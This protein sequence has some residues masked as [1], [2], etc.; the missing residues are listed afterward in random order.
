M[1]LL[2]DF[3]SCD[4]G[5]TAPQIDLSYNALDAVQLNA[6]FTLLAESGKFNGKTIKITGAIGAASCDKSIITKI[7]G[8]VIQ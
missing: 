2:F 1:P 8:N 5:S 7:G 6:L 4:W 3:E